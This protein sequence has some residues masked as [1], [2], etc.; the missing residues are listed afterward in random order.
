MKYKLP[1]QRKLRC[2]GSFTV[3]GGL[4]PL[5]RLKEFVLT[6]ATCFSLL[7]IDIFKTKD[8]LITVYYC[9]PAI[10][11]E[12]FSFHEV[13]WK[14]VTQSSLT[15]WPMACSPRGSFVHR[16]LQERTL[17]WVAT[18]FSRGSSQPR[19]QTQVS[20]LAGRLFTVWATREAWFPG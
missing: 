6:F 7:T 20:H 4:P 13:K 10:V 17:E 8:N 14:L 12:D 19:D 18:S 15:P 2:P 5:V 3:D 16:I 11:V 1:G 9:I